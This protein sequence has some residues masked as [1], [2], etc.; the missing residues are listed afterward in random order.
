MYH[1]NPGLEETCDKNINMEMHTFDE[2]KICSI[3]NYQRNISTDHVHELD[4][5]GICNVCG[6]KE[7]AQ[8]IVSFDEWYTVFKFLNF[9][10]G[11]IFI[12]APFTYD[13]K[14]YQNDTYSMKLFENILS[15][16]V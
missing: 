3:C 8:A 13:G 16:S 6:Y 7:K 11:S 4:E 9:E 1:W 2:N 5:F 10:N 15:I 14:T 12:S